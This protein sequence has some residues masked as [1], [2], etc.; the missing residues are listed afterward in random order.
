MNI[1]GAIFL[2]LALTYQSFGQTMNDQPADLQKVFNY[3][4]K[5]EYLEL[6]GDSS[7]THRF[8]LLDWAIA[9]IDGDKKTEVF[10]L[11]HPYYGE[12]APIQVYQLDADGKVSRIREA[13]APGQP[14]VRSKECLS[15]HASG[16]GMDM[17]VEANANNIKRRRFVEA[18]MKH[19]MTMIEFP[20]FFHSDHRS[21]IGG[22]YVD[23]THSTFRLE[24]T[25]CEAVQL[26]RPSSIKVGQIKGRSGKYLGVIVNKELWLYR[27]T[28]IVDGTFIDKDVTIIKLPKD[29]IRLDQSSEYIRYITKTYESREFTVKQL[30]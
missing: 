16:H 4:L 7:S 29:F 23:L 21:S 12:T 11:I 6:F 28:R 10:L 22:G 17:T 24:D 25:S 27:I 3:I 14:V 5:T 9:D 18:G 2:C 8:R 19:G 13:L 1:R 20:R 15:T 26:A 30:M